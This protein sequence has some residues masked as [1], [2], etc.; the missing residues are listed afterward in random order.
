MTRVMIVDDDY[1]T[2]Y[3]VQGVVKTLGWGFDAATSGT[4]AWQMV[5]QAI[6]DLVICEVD[7]P[8]MSGLDLTLSIKND[9][10]LSHIPVVLMG[11]PIVEGTALAA[12]CDA[13]VA[14]PFNEQTLL[15]L[16]PQLIPQEPSR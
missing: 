2:Q 14:K 13:F 7:I 16:L 3:L 9:P 1:E 15:Q 4:S 11:S 10:E 8:E 12:G 6:P 5:Q